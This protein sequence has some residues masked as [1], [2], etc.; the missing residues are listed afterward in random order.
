MPSGWLHSTTHRLDIYNEGLAKTEFTN[1]LEAL[2]K[3]NNFTLKAL[4]KLPT[5]YDYI[6]LGH[7]LVMLFRMGY[8]KNMQPRFKKCH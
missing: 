7:P 8:S 4:E 2:Y 3:E 1:T 6:R 5:A